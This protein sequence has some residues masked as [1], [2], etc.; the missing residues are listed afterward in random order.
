MHARERGIYKHTIRCSCLRA[1]YDRPSSK[2]VALKL[3]I[4]VQQHVSCGT[5]LH[6]VNSS[7]SWYN[8]IAAFFPPPPGGKCTAVDDSR[9]LP[10]LFCCFAFFFFLLFCFY[11]DALAGAGVRAIRYALEAG[12]VQVTANDKSKDACEGGSMGRVGMVVA[13]EVLY[14]YHS[15]MLFFSIQTCTAVRHG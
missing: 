5:H 7:K 12:P 1:S 13:G 6:H 2:V 11:S 3:S 8:A 9:V 4:D 14:I 10:R 15:N